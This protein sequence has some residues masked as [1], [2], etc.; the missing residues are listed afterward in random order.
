MMLCH[1]DIDLEVYPYCNVF[2]VNNFRI[3]KMF[4][5]FQFIMVYFI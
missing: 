4:V 2:L 5:I 1:T 3:T